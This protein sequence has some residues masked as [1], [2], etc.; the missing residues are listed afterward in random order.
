MPIAC[1]HLVPNQDSSAVQRSKAKQNRALPGSYTF[2]PKPG[3]H[4]DAGIEIFQ[5]TSLSAS[6]KVNHMISN[7]YFSLVL[8]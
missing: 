4:G 3:L 8:I 6:I 7:E 1:L 2:I 5:V